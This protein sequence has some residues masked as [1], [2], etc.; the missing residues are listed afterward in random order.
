MNG[1]AARR[2]PALPVGG[3][4]PWGEFAPDAWL[5]AEDNLSIRARSARQRIGYF[6]Q[7]S[8]VAIDGVLVCLGAL[9]VYGARFCFANYLSIQIT[10]AQQLVQQ[11]HTHTYPA[12]LL[13]S[14]VLIV[15]ACMT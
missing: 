5:D 9:A 7:A 10:S 13:L 8:Y 14:A 1:T 6:R 11:S 12:S 2:S 3:S 15:M 4:S